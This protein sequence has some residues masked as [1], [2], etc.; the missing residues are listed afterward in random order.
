MIVVESFRFFFFFQAE[1]GIR[2][3]LVTGVQ[4]CALPSWTGPSPSAATLPRCG[5]SWSQSASRTWPGSPVIQAR[6]FPDTG[7]P[8]SSNRVS[9]PC[10]LRW[11]S[12]CGSTWPAPRSPPV[13]RL[14]PGSSPT[15]YTTGRSPAGATWPGS[16]SCTPR[17]RSLTVTPVPPPGCSAAPRR[18]AARSIWAAVSWRSSSLRCATP[19]APTTMPGSTPARRRTPWTRRA[20]RSGFTPVDGDRERCEDH[21]DPGDPGERM[22]HRGGHRSA[23]HQPAYRLRQV[24]HRV[25]LHP[26]LQPAGQGPGRYEH[27][28]AEGQREQDQEPETLQGGGRADQQPDQHP[29]PAQGEGEEHHQ[30]VR[31]RDA[32][33]V[34]VEPEAEQHPVA[35]HHADR[36]HIADHVAEDQPAQRTRP[37]DRQTA[38]PVEDALRDVGVEIDAGT[39]AAEDDRLH[40]DARQYVLQVRLPVAAGD[41]ATEQ[42]HEHRHEHDR[43][44]AHVEQLLRVV[45]DLE[46]GPPGK[47]P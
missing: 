2:Y 12:S 46:D 25:D 8:W 15:R 28:A 13:T 16:P 3:P 27:V 43:L 45:P 38:E 18:S 37:G 35:G 34:A 14:R 33:R 6:P 7:V 23:E 41:R 24:R 31:R 44:Q 21:Q 11:A 5:S 39:H 17:S 47:C 4:T 22:P 19:S 30:R 40:R 26:G 20:R 42:E 32:E 1:D 10:P 29:H 9:R 36:H